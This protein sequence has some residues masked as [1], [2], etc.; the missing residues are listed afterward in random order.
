[1]YIF[2]LFEVIAMIR[3]SGPSLP[4]NIIRDRI[5]FPIGDNS[6]VIPMERPTV[7]KADTV[8]NTTEIKECPISKS[9]IIN[10]KNIHIDK[11]IIDKI[12]RV[13]LLS[14]VS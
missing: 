11:N 10:I 8:S 1:M 4:I 5:I 3:A 7:P 14:I 13:V 12:I 2:L 9:L 6:V